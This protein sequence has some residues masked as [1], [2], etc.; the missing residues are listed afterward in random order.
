MYAQTRLL[1][2]GA[3]QHREPAVVGVRISFK[4]FEIRAR[5]FD[6]QRRV[7]AVW[8]TG[9]QDRPVAHVGSAIDQRIVPAHG[10]TQ[11][12]VDFELVKTLADGGAGRPVLIVGWKNESRVLVQGRADQLLRRSLVQTDTCVN[13]RSVPTLIK[14]ISCFQTTAHSGLSSK[15]PRVCASV[16]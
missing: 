11:Q 3:M 14:K 16:R 12:P 5:G 1:E 2:D 15:G 9:R 13:T 8:R 4:D 7:A 6:R 10:A